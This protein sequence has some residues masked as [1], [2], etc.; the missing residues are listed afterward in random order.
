LKDSV[1]RLCLY[2]GQKKNVVLPVI[3]LSFL[4]FG[5]V[6]LA[7]AQYT[8][9]QTTPAG[10]SAGATGAAQ[11]SDTDLRPAY[12]GEPFSAA[13]VETT[14]GPAKVRL[15]GTVLLNISASDSDEVGQDVPLWAI[16]GSVPVTF[17][18]GTSKPA[19]SIHDT[20]FTARQSVFGVA[21]NPANPPSSGWIPSAL[22]EFDFFGTRPVDPTTVPQSRV[23][24]QPRLRLAYFQIQKGDWK[25]VAGQD[26]I[27]ISPLDPVSL[28]HVAVPLGYSA[29]DL[30][31]WLPQVRVDFSHKFSSETTT[32][33]QFGVLRPSFADA[34]FGDQPTAGTS[35]DSSSGLGERESQP[36]YQARL[37]ISHPLQNSTATVGVSGHYGVERLGATRKAD[38][39][40]FAFDLR[41]PIMSHLF[42]RGEGY[43][44]SNLVAFGG[45]VLSGVAALA[46]PPPAVNTFSRFRN[47]GDGGG[48]GEF[49]VPITPRNVV[50]FGVGT[51]DPVNKDLLPGST[52]QKNS[53]AWASYFRKITNNISLGFEWSNWQFRTIQ[54][55]NNNPAGRGAYGRGN[56]FNLALAYQ[57]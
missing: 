37:A 31:G 52:H 11:N 7:R 38:S 40:A 48:W 16:P 25:F 50:Y 22:V 20:I 6:T 12:P 8:Q 5:P 19:G 35:I 4:C 26:K 18:D 55:V 51:D 46:V 21:L 34:R 42:F 56:V 17:P 32:L 13:P 54:F 29:G 27:I 10:Q 28:S 15:Y 3:L 44:G 41:V 1:A 23:L 45:G 47:I 49:T 36:F 24:N 57:F 39:W 2:N 33:F 30:F 9:P 43:L 14:I 53:F